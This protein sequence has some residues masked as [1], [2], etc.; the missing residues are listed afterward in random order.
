MGALILTAVAAMALF[1]SGCS[2]RVPVSV[3]NQRDDHG[4]VVP[5]LTAPTGVVVQTSA[6]TAA[7]NP[8]L[9]QPDPRIPEYQPVP[10]TNW[11]GWVDDALGLAGV[12][13]PLLGIPAVGGWAITTQRLL[14]ARKD[15]ALALQAVKLTAAHGDMME[16]A[17]TDT[18]VAR[19][20]ELSAM[21]QTAAGVHDLIQA[22]RGKVS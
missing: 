1:F 7:L 19:T 13:L 20:K 17:E 16:R 6:T 8:T 4:S 2:M 21:A 5:L 15:K 22:A 9:P 10:P 12:V 3:A 18:D 11:W 14:Q